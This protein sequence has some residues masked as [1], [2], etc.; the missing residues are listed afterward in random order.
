[1]A[2]VTL[3]MSDSVHASVIIQHQ[4]KQQQQQ[5]LCST[6]EAGLSQREEELVKIQPHLQQA[7]E[8]EKEEELE[9]GVG[10]CD[11]LMLV[12]ALFGIEMCMSFEQIYEILM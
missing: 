12:S 8:D 10:L 1:M 5:H 9:E 4:L 6:Q 2:G 7:R 3:S 11:Q